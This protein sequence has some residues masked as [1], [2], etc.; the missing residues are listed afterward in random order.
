MMRILLITLMLIVGQQ[1]LQAK[2]FFSQTKYE[3]L[4]KQHGLKN[5]TISAIHQDSAGFIWL[6]TDVG[7]SRYDGVNFHNYELIEREPWAIYS[8]YETSNQLLWLWSSNL[9]KLICFNKETSNYI[10][11]KNSGTIQRGNICE[12][13]GNLYTI[14]EDKAFELQYSDITDSIELTYKALPIEDPVFQVYGGKESLLLTTTDGI[15]I[16][17]PENQHTIKISFQ[18]IGIKKRQEIEHIKC[19]DDH[20]WLYGRQIETICYDI[21]NRQSRKMGFS[22]SL[23]ALQQI[24]STTFITATWSTID[25]IQFEDSRYTQSKFKSTNLCNGMDAYSSIIRNRINSMYMDKENEVLWIGIS[26]RGLLKITFRGNRI[27][28]IALPQNVKSVKQITQDIKGYIWLTTEGNGIFRSVDNIVSPDMKFVL[29]KETDAKATYYLHQDA[30]K[31]IWFGG[32]NDD[33]IYYNP[34]TEKVEHI[35]TSIHGKDISTEIHALFLNSRNKLWIATKEGLLIFDNLEKSFNTF[36]P[37]SSEYGLITS[38]SEDGG[39]QMWLGTEKGVKK[40]DFDGN[41]LELTGGFEENANLTP[42]RVTALYLNKFNQLFAAYNDKAVQ[43]NVNE[44]KINEALTL[45]KNFSSGHITCFIDDQG[46]NTWLGTNSGVIVVNNQTLES[47]LYELPESYLGVHQLNDGQL[48]WVNSNGLLYFNPEQVKQ[49]ISKRDFI[50]S[51]IEV[52]YIKVKVNEELNG[53]V[54]LNRSAHLTDKL[55]LN[56]NNNNLRIYVS[57]LK[58]DATPSKVEYRLLPTDTTWSSTYNAYIPL[59]NIPSGK[60]T[61]EMRSPYLSGKENNISKLKITINPNWTETKWMWLLYFVITVALITALY[62]Y[63]KI[64]SYREYK[65]QLLQKSL[66]EEKEIQEIKDKNSQLRGQLHYLLVKKLRTPVSLLLAP[67]KEQMGNKELPGNT[68]QKLLIAY[69]N[70]LSVQDFC[71]RLEDAFQIEAN[72]EYTIAPYT[73]TRIANG[74]IRSSYDL[75]NASSV[76]FHYDKDKQMD[77]EIW[78]DKQ[79]IRFVLQSILSNS[80]QQ[81][82]YQG[83]IWFD[84]NTETK[85]GKEY[86]TFSIISKAS[87]NHPQNTHEGA[88]TNEELVGGEIIEVITQVHS[89]EIEVHTNNNKNEVQ[90]LIPLGKEHWAGVK[91]VSMVETEALATEEE[92][93]AQLFEEEKEMPTK[94]STGSVFEQ[95]ETIPDSKLKLLIIEDNPDIRLY[96]KAI[97]SNLY[98]V[99]LAE[100]GEE[101][102]AIARRELPNLI[103]SDVMMP[104]MDGFECLRILKEDLNTCHIPVIIL[105][106]LTSD[107]DIVKGTDLGADDYILKPFNPEVLRAKVK[108]LIRSR[109]ELKQ[110]YTKLLT[111][112]SGNEAPTNTQV[113]TEE[114]KATEDP[115]IKKIMQ[116]VQDNLD[117][118]DFNVKKLSEMLFMSQPTLYR[119]VKQLT[120]FTIIELV[121]GMRLKEAA[122]LLKTR[123]YSIQEVSEKVG[124]NDIPTFRKHFVS[125]YGTTP[126][127]FAG[128]EENK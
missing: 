100:N 54:I 55:E 31:N 90:L 21:T 88:F 83:D 102:I 76:K 58:Y 106:A 27:S 91:N 7:L 111:T 36:I 104:V 14:K 61:L 1:T 3:L 123:K 19:Q 49:W 46:G 18:E 67:F 6:G 72:Q 38:I 41:T 121:R 115:L 118:P 34:S 23:L 37:N 65:Y 87:K 75:L 17:Q 4:N 125:L 126:S 120:G 63:Y 105:T 69:R 108:R 80:L 24:D 13:K 94:V 96:M 32:N 56:Y 93:P 122:E 52:N 47:Y 10:P 82:N 110:I 113:E 92:L 116:I 74:V 44:L 85:E 57:N 8:I 12:V 51:D 64:R 109:T 89:G 40:A 29:W 60:Y 117:N 53:Q 25:I 66:Q 98:Q 15:V 62:F 59:N 28:R 33:L 20:L 97:F 73:P 50:V 86:C 99:F 101:G 81:L 112:F 5:N 95:I 107:E 45:H 11:V 30:Q 68:K 79:R 2:E 9:N 71:S 77:T 124:Y 48:L 43:I 22:D 39:G 35:H 16:Y 70:A 119:K 26:G 127:T 78:V 42:N 128:N 103:L 84:I 114:V